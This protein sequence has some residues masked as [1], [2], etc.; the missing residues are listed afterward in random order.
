[1][2]I[3]TNRI[4]SLILALGI[5]GGAYCVFGKPYK[6]IMVPFL[7]LVWVCVFSGLRWVV[8]PEGFTIMLVGLLTLHGASWVA[9]WML[10]RE[11][12]KV[13]PAW[14]RGLMLLVLV[15]INGGMIISCHTYKSQWFGFDLYQIPSDSMHPT[16][17]RGD[18]VMVNTWAY[19][20]AS[21]TIKDI[22]IIKRSA[23]GM[24]LAKRLTRIRTA[25]AGTELFLED[26]NPN[27]S[28]DSRRFGWVTDTYLIGKVEF[29][30]FS[31]V[32]PRRVLRSID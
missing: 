30:W 7:G 10:Q 24:A 5:P 22:L 3:N 31:F 21:P 23:S 25:V 2:Q 11:N 20:T 1:M 18:I 6:A 28:V 19:D 13:T 12:T 15:L 32:E 14:R 27:R 29:V 8:T 9:G 26:D 17:Q 16:L 4:P